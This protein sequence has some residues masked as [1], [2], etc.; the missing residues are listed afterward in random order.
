V[1]DYEALS[2]SV[3]A[4]FEAA[5]GDVIDDVEPVFISKRATGEDV[6]RFDV[7]VDDRTLTAEAHPIHD[8]D[9]EELMILFCET[10]LRTLTDDY[11]ADKIDRV[12]LAVGETEREFDYPRWSY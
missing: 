12:I 7:T 9:I 4:I 3:N 6:V 8:V 5:S 1:S 10:Y 2:R 11:Y